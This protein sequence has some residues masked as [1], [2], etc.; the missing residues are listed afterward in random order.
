MFFQVNY[1]QEERRKK[2]TGMVDIIVE[3]KRRK[4]MGLATKKAK[5]RKLSLTSA[6]EVIIFFNQR[7]LP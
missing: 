3:G 7:K 2:I 4:L 1:F 5:R 6:I